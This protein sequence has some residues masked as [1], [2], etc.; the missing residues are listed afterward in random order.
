[1]KRIS[2]IV[3]LAIVGMTACGKTTKGKLVNDWKVVSSFEEYEFHNSNDE[4]ST[5]TTTTTENEVTISEFYHP[6]TGPETTNSRTGNLNSYEFLIKKDGTW[7]SVREISFEGGSSSSLDRIEQ[8]GTWSFLKKNKSDDF[9]KNERV[10]FNVLSS[11]SLQTVSSGGVVLSSNST[12]ETF[13]TGEKVLVYTIKTSKKDQLEMELE[14][15][16]SSTQ[17]SGANNS[18]SLVQ[19]LTLQGK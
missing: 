10:H 11:K 17:S 16:Y 14:N 6:S 13:I 12:D 5:N 19:K 4:H 3:C 15:N 9:K 18:N 8:S 1:M 2:V 7:S